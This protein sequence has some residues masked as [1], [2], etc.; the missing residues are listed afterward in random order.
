M[1]GQNRKITRKVKIQ[2]SLIRKEKNK[3]RIQGRCDSCDEI[4]LAPEKV[5]HTSYM[6]L[7]KKCFDKYYAIPLSKLSFSQ[8]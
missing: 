7:C 5:Y 4:I 3:D 1:K 2:E 6:S 8:G